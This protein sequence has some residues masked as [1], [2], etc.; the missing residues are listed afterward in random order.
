M[1]AIEDALT[2]LSQP[3]DGVVLGAPATVACT[4]INSTFGFTVTSALTGAAWISGRV[5]ARCFHVVAGLSCYCNDIHTSALAAVAGS[6][7]S[8]RELHWGAGSRATWPPF[9]SHRGEPSQLARWA[10]ARAAEAISASPDIDLVGLLSTL[11]T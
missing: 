7:S 9:S 11:W 4:T 6:C 3:E 8:L 2:Q 10:P 5:A 1:A